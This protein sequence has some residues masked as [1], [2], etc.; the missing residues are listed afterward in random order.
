MR[1]AYLT[2]M[3]I[4]SWKKRAP[5]LSCSYFMGEGQ[6]TGWLILASSNGSFAL[7]QEL[8]GAIASAIDVSAVNHFE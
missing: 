6:A 4:V 2:A 8:M 3:G 7:E 1:E 5:L